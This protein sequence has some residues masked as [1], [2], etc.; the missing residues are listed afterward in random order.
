[1]SGILRR[2]SKMCA[3]TVGGPEFAIAAIASFTIFVSSHHKHFSQPVIGRRGI[4]TQDLLQR[5]VRLLAGRL[6]MEF[7]L[8]ICTGDSKA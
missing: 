4:H 7:C 6:F 8:H 3:G 1:M 2:N 5:H